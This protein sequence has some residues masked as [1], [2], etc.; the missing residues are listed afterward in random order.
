M[1][2]NPTCQKNKVEQIHPVILLHPFHIRVHKWES[3]SMDFITGLPKLFGKDCIFLLLDRITKFS[4]L[5]DVTMI[6][7]A[8]Q[9]AELFFKE[10]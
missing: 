1:L 8:A 10:F 3:I 2:M 4:H 9:V 7:S 5:F 6:F